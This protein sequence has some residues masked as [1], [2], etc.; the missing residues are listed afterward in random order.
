MNQMMPV[1]PVKAI[2]FDYSALQADVAAD[3]RAAAQR[4]RIFNE[5]MME[6]VANV[7][8]ELIA[9]KERLDHGAFTP[10]VEAE[11][12]LS[13]R[14]AQNYMQ[15]AQRL[16]SNAKCVSHL[17]LTTGFKLTSSST[18]DRV[19]EEV[20]TRSKAGD[21]PDRRQVEDLIHKAKEADE[22]AEA[23]AKLTPEER[24]KSL[25]AKQARELR[26][27]KW[28]AQQDADCAKQKQHDERVVAFLKEKLQPDD[29]NA[30]MTLAKRANWHHVEC[31]LTGSSYPRA[32]A[33]AP[34]A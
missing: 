24:K 29:I 31:V 28:K 18:P 1:S 23:E 16:G 15:M 6:N 21:P 4:I 12:G 8:R 3:A 2:T 9:M 5:T 33:G 30:F 25:Q 26:I 10:W 11:L 17:P 34:V 19:V 13:I 32:L 14:T 22:K 7:G 27:K 20:I